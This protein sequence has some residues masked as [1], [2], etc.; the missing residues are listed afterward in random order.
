MIYVFYYSVERPFVKRVYLAGGPAPA[1]PSPN[2]RLDEIEARVFSR[3]KREPS[4]YP[5]LF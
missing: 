1:S 3:K 2:S 4:F 5:G